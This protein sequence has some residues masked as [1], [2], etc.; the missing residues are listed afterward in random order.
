MLPGVYQDTWLSVKYCKFLML[1]IPFILFPFLLFQLLPFIWT[2]STPVT[3]FPAIETLSCGLSCRLFPRLSTV[4]ANMSWPS[5][6]IIFYVCLIYSFHRSSLTSIC[7][8]CPCSIF[9]RR[10]PRLFIGWFN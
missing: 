10:I 7:H 3:W 5:T 8:S 4:S 2:F 9:L 1:L 6:I